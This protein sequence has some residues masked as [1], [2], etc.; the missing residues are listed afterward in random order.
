MAVKRWTSARE[1]CDICEASIADTEFVDAK[2]RMGPWALMCMDCWVEVGAYRTF[3]LGK[4]QHYDRH[5]VKI[6][7]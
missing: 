5:A 3:G 1:K 6:D 2:T 7:G 4:G